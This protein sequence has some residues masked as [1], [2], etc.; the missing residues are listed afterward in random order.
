[1]KLELKDRN[2]RYSTPTVHRRLGEDMIGPVTGCTMSACYEAIHS[3]LGM[4]MKRKGSKVYIYNHIL[5]FSTP[6]LSG[7][8]PRFEFPH[9]HLFSGFLLL[10][11]GP[12]RTPREGEREVL[13]RV[14][15]KERRLAC[16]DSG[17]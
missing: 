2:I 5:G 15:G 1:M 12:D 3:P 17:G 16:G 4:P 11:K 6:S 8:P 10:Q 14:E 13:E 9:F 7:F